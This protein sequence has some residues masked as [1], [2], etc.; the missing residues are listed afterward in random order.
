MEYFLNSSRTI[1]LI[2]I[3]ITALF[4]CND[5]QKKNY[6]SLSGR[7]TNRFSDVLEI[8]NDKNE[9]IKTIKLSIDGAFSD[10]IHLNKGLYGLSDGN[11]YSRVF[12]FPGAN[13]N[14][15]ID[16]KEFGA[17]QV[18]SGEG[19]KE[20]NFAT[21][22]HTSQKALFDSPD[23]FELSEA[24]FAVALD[25]I[26]NSYEQ[27]LTDQE[28]LDPYYIQKDLEEN[29]EIVGILSAKY[30]DKSMYNELKGQLS[31][32]FKNYENYEGGTTSLDDLKGKYV[33]IDV[34]ATWCKPCIKEIPALK[35]LEKEFGNQMH[36]VS[37]SVDN[38][39]MHKVWKQ[40]IADKELKGIQ[41]I[42]NNDGN[43]DFINDYKVNTIP[44]FILIDP[45]GIVVKPEASRPSDPNTRSLLA[46]L[47]TQ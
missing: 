15:R 33:Y 44:R 10:T 1:I 16:A 11:N 36:F 37:I 29:E 30:L 41:L 20:N 31:P 27:Q 47:L 12:L 22:K 8:T 19:S 17:S 26:R 32:L 46:Y 4:S 14:I 28:E 21:A 18:F 3:A 5:S 13:L 38:K 2:T 24:D 7:V 35:E 23:I 45:N 43:T 9:V 40:L 6:T 42:A 25:S 39:D 34:W